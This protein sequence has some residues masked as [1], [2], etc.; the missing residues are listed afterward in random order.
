VI[1]LHDLP[2][3]AF[4]QPPLTT[5]RMPRRDLGRRALDLLRTT[6][7][8]EPVSEVLSGPI[9]LVPRASTGPPPGMG[10]GR[11]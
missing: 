8:S 1:A 10:R 5:V 11:S 7:A 9:E 3:A 2:L 4:L 6:A